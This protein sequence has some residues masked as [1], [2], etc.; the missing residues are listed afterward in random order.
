MKKQNKNVSWT[1]FTDNLKETSAI[2]DNEMENSLKELNLFKSAHLFGLL[3]RRGFGLR[4]VIFSVLIWP[5]LSSGSL[6]FFCGNRLPAYIK[7][8]KDVIYDFLKRQ[9]INWRGWRFHSAKQ[10]YKKH[11]LDKESIRAATFDDTNKRRRGK[12]VSAVSS[13]YDNS[14]GRT[15][16]GQQ[17]LEMG[18]S[19]P[20]GYLP[21]D[22]Q[23]YVGKKKVQEGKHALKDKRS[24]V[25]KDYSVAKSENKNQMLRKMLKR[26]IRGALSFTHVIADSW[27]GNKKNIKTVVSLGL[28]GIF[29][30]RR[31]N[32]QYL[33]NGN[34]YT[35][36]ELYAFVK[37]RM[38]K[39]KVSPWKTYSLTVLLNLS[40]DKDNPDFLPVKLLFSAPIRQR[41]KETWA[42]FLSTDVNLAAEEILEVYSLRWSIEVYF[43]E[44][45]QNLGFLKE[46][47]GDYAVHYASIHLCAIRYI[48][49]A[50]RMLSSGE[51]FGRVRD[52]VTKQLELLTF[53][54]LL[55]ELFKSLI[56]GI[57][58]VVKGEVSGEIIE[59]IKGKIS[60]GISE[61]LDRALQLDDHYSQSEF[62]AEKIRAFQD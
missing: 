55:W 46:Q 19:T 44:I 52:R 20:K 39:L 33:L 23:I 34:P 62:K 13:H 21:L 31:G 42:V 4:Q 59:L 5:L 32:L 56:Y 18:L 16:T 2:V 37:R 3:K 1:P 24:A 9:D 40:D 54:R 61:F 38:R 51:A 48:L 27:F 47:S 14:L 22:S 57:L 35:A 15:I 17:V 12:K 8:G 50:H 7:G 30:M 41:G 45:K 58:D 28:V 60:V 6:R 26:A 25:G 29:R 53:A 11:E 36:A 43:K 49:I 10:F